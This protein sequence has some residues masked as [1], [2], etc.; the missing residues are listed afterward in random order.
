MQTILVTGG[1]GQLGR[2]LNEISTQYPFHFLFTDLDELNITDLSSVQDFF[3]LH[4][5]SYCINAAAYTAVD[6]AESDQELAFLVNVNG[7]QNLAIACSQSAI[8][9]IHIST[10][11]VFDGNQP[12]LYTETSKENPVSIYGKSKLEGERIVQAVHKQTIIIRT[13]WL[14]SFYGKNFVK[15]MLQLSREKESLGVI[16]DQTGTPTYAN[17]LAQAI[18]HIIQQLNQPGQADQYWGLYN[19]SNEGTASWY[20]FAKAIFDVS[21]ISIKLKPITTP[22]YPTPAKRPAY[23]VLDKSKIKTTF[24]LA[25]PYWR[26][27]LVKCIEKLRT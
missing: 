16:C 20:D 4:K 8:P 5:I 2:E 26:D 15:T 7:A 22:E 21:A 27:S 18:M 9:L 11:F 10:D 17:D 12:L 19:Y 23:S 6:K 13:S 14:Y 1:N 24:K 25:I 3:R